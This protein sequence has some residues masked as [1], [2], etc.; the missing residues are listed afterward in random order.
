MRFFF[1]ALLLV[2]G[3]AGAAVGCDLGGD[4][5]FYRF[6]GISLQILRKNREINKL[7]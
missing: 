4:R 6:G 5:F 3:R 2:V 1:L 7:K